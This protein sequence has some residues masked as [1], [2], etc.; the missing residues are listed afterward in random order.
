MTG[1]VSLDISIY[2]L[3]NSWL[4]FSRGKRRTLEFDTFAY[5]IESELFALEQELADKMYHHGGYTTFVVSDRKK[6]TVSVASI[7]DR[8]VHRLLY[9]YLVFC[10]DHTFIYDAWSCRTGKGLLGAIER[11][12]QFVQSFPNGFV[13]RSDIRKF[14]DTVSH[15]TLLSLLPRRIKDPI[16]LSLANEIV[17][18]YSTTDVQKWPGGGRRCW[19]ANWQC[20]ESGICKHISQ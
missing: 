5:N 2:R 4:R 6:R 15:E 17:S 11:A 14:F 9:D 16:A 3:W 12:Q 19:L 18:S 13:W 7:R 8:V 1:N 20:D 10:F